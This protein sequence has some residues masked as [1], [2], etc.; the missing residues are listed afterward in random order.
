MMTSYSSRRSA[1]RRG[2]VPGR[3]ALPEVTLSRADLRTE[4]DPLRISPSSSRVLRS[5]APRER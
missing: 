2:E 3:A 4:G 5:A 1:R